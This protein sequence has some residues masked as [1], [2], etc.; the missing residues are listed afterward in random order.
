MDGNLK[1]SKIYGI[2]NIRW[3]EENVAGSPKRLLPARTPSNYYIGRYREDNMNNIINFS[4]FSGQ[5]FEPEPQALAPVK[6]GRPR[7]TDR[8]KVATLRQQGYT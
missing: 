2:I 6:K 1:N 7:T 4:E 3:G 8:E 5:T